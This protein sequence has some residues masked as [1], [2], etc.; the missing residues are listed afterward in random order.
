MT[1]QFV[2]ALKSYSTKTTVDISKTTR[3]TIDTEQ[4]IN[5]ALDEIAAD[6]NI[7]VTIET[8]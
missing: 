3:L 4:L 8:L 5:K 6:Q 2:G 1:I 7:K